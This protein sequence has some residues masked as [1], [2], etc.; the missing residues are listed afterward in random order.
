M[1]RMPPRGARDEDSPRPGARSDSGSSKKPAEAANSLDVRVAGLLTSGEVKQ[2]ATMVIRGYGPGILRYLRALLGDETDAREAF[3]DFCERLWT[4]LPDYRREAAV[5]TWALRLAWSAAADLRKQAW[6]R[7]R[8]RLDTAEADALAQTKAS[9]TESHPRL[10]RQRLSLERLRQS[11]PLEDQ[12]LLQLRINQ[13]LSWAECARVMAP[14]GRQP[15]PE[16]LMKRYERIKARLGRLAR[17]IG[18]R[19]RRG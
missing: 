17:P 9:R 4:G 5:R 2:A 18:T 3:S 13:G 1:P 16:A 19:P 14:E 12:S 7:R 11:L 10:E 8:R 15:T 6:H